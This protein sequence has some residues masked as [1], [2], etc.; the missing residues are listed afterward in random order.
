MPATARRLHDIR[1]R[2]VRHGIQPVAINE[3]LAYSF[4]FKPG[5]EGASYYH[6]AVPLLRRAGQHAHAVGH[7][8]A[9]GSLGPCITNPDPSI[10]DLS[11]GKLGHG[12]HRR[13]P[14]Q[15]S[16]SNHAASCSPSAAAKYYGPI[17]IESG[18][19]SPAESTR[20]LAAAFAPQHRRPGRR[21]HVPRPSS[22][23]RQPAGYVLQRS[24]TRSGPRQ[25]D[26][27]LARPY[28]AQTS[29]SAYD[30]HGVDP[31]DGN[32]DDARPGHHADSATATTDTNNLPRARPTP[33][34][35]TAPD[36]RPAI[37][38]AGMTYYWLC[39]RR[40]ASQFLPPNPT[41]PPALEPHDRGRFDAVPLH[42]RREEPARP[43]RP[44]VTTIRSTTGTNTLYSAQRSQPYRGGH[45]VRLPERHDDQHVDASAQHG[46]RLQRADRGP[47]TT[48]GSDWRQTASTADQRRSTSGR[49]SRRLH[50]PH[51][52]ASQ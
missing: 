10:L 1:A 41:P 35:A 40:P 36:P 42:R 25:R 31:R 2:P 24:P 30:Q 18:R 15:P 19:C 37:A 17:A 5:N 11:A 28:T 3:T 16:R 46:L 48:T 23:D 47:S 4:L 21:P 9:S 13:R 32:A 14:G 20:Q 50:V 43:T 27:T 52:R 34:P 6:A 12:D 44:A 51:A 7:R 26:R 49:R 38:T 39:L 29:V 8:H 45:A 33:Y 22:T